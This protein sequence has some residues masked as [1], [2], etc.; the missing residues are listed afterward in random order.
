MIKQWKNR[1][2]DTALRAKL[3][4]GVSVKDAKNIL[5]PALASYTD[6]LIDEISLLTI[7]QHGI[8][9]ACGICGKKGF[10]KKGL[11]LHLKRKHY[12]QI[13]DFLENR[14]QEII[15]HVKKT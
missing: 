2:I 3:N 6:F 5:P 1:F 11:F 13:Q 4:L 9:L 14:I 7:K 12:S 8:G 15:K 10:T